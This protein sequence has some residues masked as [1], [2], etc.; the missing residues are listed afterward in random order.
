MCLTEAVM[1]EEQMEA[2]MLL[3]ID[4]DY[5]AHHLVEFLKCRRKHFPWVIA[6]KP[7]HHVWMDCQADEYVTFVFLSL[8]VCL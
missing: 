4:R 2:A 1:T 8:S 5:C 3:P 6:C 7:E